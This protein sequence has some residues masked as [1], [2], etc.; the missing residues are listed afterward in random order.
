L[1]LVG[2]AAEATEAAAA[3]AGPAAEEEDEEVAEGW[4][5]DEKDLSLR[6]P[7]RS[8]QLDELKVET[9]SK[10]KSKSGKA[11]AKD[12]R[13]GRGKHA[14]VGG[15]LSGAMD[16]GSDGD[17]DKDAGVEVSQVCSKR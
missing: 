12:K 16:V 9:K 5:W 14:A 6:R 17:D 13:K 1:E 11:K 2:A 4:A 8:S 10:G 7:P 15:I 3:A